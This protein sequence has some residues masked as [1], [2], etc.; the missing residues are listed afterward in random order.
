[1]I[2]P[3]SNI[4]DHLVLNNDYP[5][6]KKS[7]RK[8]SKLNMELTQDFKELLTLLNANK[9][10]KID[11]DGVAIPYISLKDLVFNKKATA[12]PQDI[13]DAYSL[14]KINNLEEEWN[15]DLVDT[16]EFIVLM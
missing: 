13:T 16:I 4:G 2:I 1:M 12:R 5:I 9:W 8:L 6:S 10:N 11:V 7:E 14:I 3:I 15:L